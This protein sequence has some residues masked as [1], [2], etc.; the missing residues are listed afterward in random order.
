[1]ISKVAKL[2]LGA[3]SSAIGQTL[4]KHNWYFQDRVERAS[5]DGTT[6]QL[7]SLGV[8]RAL[9]NAVFDPGE[10]CLVIKD[11]DGNN[12][13][14]KPAMGARK[15]AALTP[16]EYPIDLDSN[17]YPT[18]YQLSKAAFSI[19]NVVSGQPVISATCVGAM[20]TVINTVAKDYTYNMTPGNLC[21]SLKFNAHGDL[22]LISVSE[23]SRRAAWKQYA[24]SVNDLDKVRG[25]YAS[26]YRRGGSGSFPCSASSAA[27]WSFFSNKTLLTPTFGSSKYDSYRATW[28]I[29]LAEQVSAIYVH[30]TYTVAVSGGGQET[31]Y[32]DDFFTDDATIFSNKGL[33]DV[34]PEPTVRDIRVGYVLWNSGSARF[35][36]KQALTFPEA[37]SSHLG[38]SGTL[39]HPSGY[40][41]GSNHYVSGAVDIHLS[42]SAAAFYNVAN[43]LFVSAD[44]SGSATCATSGSATTD[45]S[46]RLFKN[47]PITSFSFA[48]V[49]PP[50]TGDVH[51]RIWWA[52]GV[53]SIDRTWLGVH[54]NQS[55]YVSTSGG[56]PSTVMYVQLTT[57]I[58]CTLNVTMRVLVGGKGYIDYAASLSATNGTST[59]S[60]IID[61]DSL[62]TST[63]AT[64]QT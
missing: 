38:D 49:K 40:Y 28:A 16:V 2:I 6:Y 32:D 34:A 60:I 57:T 4:K 47:Y 11:I 63:G 17:G 61:G 13:L 41:N 52:G 7:S 43:G 46:R 30:S 22:T 35:L 45:F 5:D 10:T 14:Y 31:R 9:N 24:V 62:T 33:H 26:A 54:P 51:I 36:N 48:W 12:W 18:A 50:P 8:G 3:I 15:P 27:S 39:F 25:I 1:M 53:V 20:P 59:T 23:F 37:G 42:N 29:N 55:Y 19:C 58:A 56:A 44:A 21:K 64:V